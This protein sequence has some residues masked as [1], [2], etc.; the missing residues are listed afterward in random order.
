MRSDNDI[1]YLDG[2]QTQV[3]QAFEAFPELGQL[4]ILNRHEDYDDHQPVTRLERN[5]TAINVQWPK[6]GG[7][8]VVPEAAV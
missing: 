2:W 4:G 5:G 7:N 6:V 1:E 8:C 3:E